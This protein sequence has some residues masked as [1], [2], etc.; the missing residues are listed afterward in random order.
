M[1]TRL[2]TGACAAFL[3]ASSL[4]AQDYKLETFTTPLPDVPSAYASV[5][6]RKP[7]YRVTG[8]NGPWCEIWLRISVPTGAKPADPAISFAIP[9]GT[10]IGILRFPAQAADRRGQTIKPG[11]Y[12]LRYSDYPVD[13]AHQGVAPQRDFALLT[14]VANDPDPNATPSF[15]ALVKMSAEASGTPHPAVLSLETPA[16]STFPAVTKEGD[17]DW[18]LNVKIGDLPLA[19]I[20]AGKYEG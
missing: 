7:A 18:V 9:Q 4:S 14:P 12:T 5:I 2:L 16:G 13:G 1:I 3:A 6:F 8:P 19:I 10:L 20:V 11:V 17:H 15:E